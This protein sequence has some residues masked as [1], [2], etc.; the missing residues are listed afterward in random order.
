MIRKGPAHPQYVSI[1]DGVDA[2]NS[3][4]PFTVITK[5]SGILR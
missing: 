5:S 3:G 4:L 1:R 2:T